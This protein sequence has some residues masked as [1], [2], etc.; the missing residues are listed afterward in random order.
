M[1]SYKHIKICGGI[2]YIINGCVTRKNIDDRSHSGYFMVYAATTG[3]IIYW[4]KYH[5]FVVHV[6]HHVWFDEYNSSLSI[7]YNHTPCYL[8]IQQYPASIIHNS[9]PIMLIPYKL[10]LT[11]APFS[12][13]TIVTYEIELPPDGKRIDF[14]LLD[15]DEFTIPYVTDKIPNSPAGHQ[16]STQAKQNMWIVDINGEDSITAQGALD[17]INRHQTLHEKSKV[18]ISI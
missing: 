5:P 4:R 2:V 17:E 12:N 15:D 8:L 1:P 7:E 11:Y 6:S 14:N 16:L 9:E 13:T 10:D 18:K 3:V